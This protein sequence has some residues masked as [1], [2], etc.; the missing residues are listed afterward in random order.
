MKTQKP[1]QVKSHE[2]G[3][4]L[5]HGTAYTTDEL[6]DFLRPSEQKPAT[7]VSKATEA[8]KKVLNVK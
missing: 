3:Q 5:E 7:L 4:K 8:L 1:K 6:P 2:E